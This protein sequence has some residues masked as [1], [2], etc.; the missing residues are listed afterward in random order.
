MIFPSSVVDPES[1]H[2]M[3]KHLEPNLNTFTPMLTYLLRCNVDVTSLLSGTAIKAIIA[4]VA[5]YITKTPMKTHVIFDAV[6]SIF[7][8]NST[9]LSGNAEQKEKARKI[10]TTS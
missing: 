8:K 1:G 3:L 9:L 4:Y 7:D 5:D 2:I 10:L 6:K